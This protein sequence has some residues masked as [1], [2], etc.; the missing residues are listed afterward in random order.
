MNRFYLT[1][2]LLLG[3]FFGRAQTRAISGRVLDS[4]TGQT[5]PGASVSIKGSSQAT[6]TDPNGKFT[7]NSPGNAPV[8]ILVKSIGFA[9]QSIPVGA[10]EQDI[11]IKLIAQIKDLDELV[12][13]G[14]GTMKRRD[15]TGAVASVKATDIIKAPTHNAVEAIQGRAAGVDI[16]RSSGNAGAGVNIQ[17]RG[18]RSISNNP[19]PLYVID[20]VQVGGNIPNPNANGV[21]NVG[22]INN[23][24]PN[25]IET[26]DVLL[27]ASSTAIYG[28]QGANGVVIITTKK[29]KSG[30]AKISYNGYYGINGET[31]FP[32][33]RTGDSYLNLRREAFRNDAGIITQTD[34]QIFN[35]AGE[36]SAIA[37]GAFVNWVDLATRTGRQ[38][39]HNLSI[40]GGSENTKALFS[41]GYFNEEGALKNNDFDRYNFRYNID[42]K[43][44]DWFK[45]GVVGQLS[46]TKTNA[47]RDPLSTA[48]TAVPL[49]T[50]YAPDGSVNIFP[51]A[52]FG[53]GNTTLSPL[54]DERPGAAIDEALATEINATAYAELTPIKGFTYRMNFGAILSN[55]RR[56]VFNDALSTSQNNV[57]Y[58]SASLTNQNGRY[59]NWDNVITYTKQ[60]NKHSFTG[61]VLSSYIHSDADANM[62]MGIRQVVPSQGFSNLFGTE[63]TSRTTTSEFRRYDLLAFA[64]RLNYSYDGKYLFQATHRWDGASMLAPGRKWDSFASASAGWVI[65]RENFLKD[66][67][68]I[69]N[70]KLR[71]SYG[72]AG[73]SGS[74]SPYGSQSLLNSVP[75]GFGEVPAPGYAFSGS[76]ANPALGWERSTTF[77]IGIDFAVLNNRLSGTL[78]TYRTK[79]TDI[80]LARSLPLS[81]GQATITQNIGATLNKGINATLTSVNVQNKNFN[82]STTATFSRNKESIT[83]LIDGRNIIASSNPEENSLFIGSPVRVFYT[84]KKDGIWQLN[85]NPSAV[86]QA[87]Q[88]FRFGDIKLRDLNGD[89]I[90]DATNDRQIV[91]QVQPKWYGGLQNSFRYK[92]LDLSIFMVVRWGQTVKA[93]FIGRYNPGGVANGPDNFD[94]WTVNNPSNDFPRPRQG[95]GVANVYPNQYQSLLYVDGSFLKIKNVQLGYTFPKTLTDKLKLGSLRAYATASNLYT[96][97]KNE[98]LRDYDPERGGAESSPLSKQFVFGFNLDL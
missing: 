17:I 27:D 71:T 46:Y 16:T 86:T 54:T 28:S 13:V 63:A 5:I 22:N 79:T 92:N 75:I 18:T 72:S 60:I 7:L 97:A 52:G 34:D 65:S 90:I 73:N 4:S 96:Y 68:V 24:N 74:V 82:W 89:N 12:V 94:Y 29:G 59:Y 33:P 10:N 50:A 40:S 14:F 85:E 98:L 48:L 81:T 58:A 9:E 38:Q 69:N 1:F 76:V 35:G 51:M 55:T 2:L 61:T 37:S 49:G 44:N 84:F 91:G 36:L 93:E 23:L 15:L 21:Q 56:G 77:D 30:K 43:V 66:V 80:I 19:N 32:Q 62:A 25:D 39:S 83:S 47:R 53:V 70:L 11:T 42:H 67:K 3:V 78:E 95:N 31:A 45:A 57:R 26:I 20:G 6:Q 87:G 88:P 8:V 64:G 41:L